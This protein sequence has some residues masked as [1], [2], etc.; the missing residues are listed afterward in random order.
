MARLPE[1]GS[2]WSSPTQTGHAV[3]CILAHS[4]TEACEAAPALLAIKLPV[5]L[6]LFRTSHARWPPNG[7]DDVLRVSGD[8]V[9]VQIQA[10]LFT[11]SRD[12]RQTHRIHD[13]HYDVGGPE[14]GNRN[15]YAADQLGH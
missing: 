2:F 6:F 3:R 5:R 10:V 14:S 1:R 8:A 13:P 12:A 15:D 7:G 9:L 4:S 11:F